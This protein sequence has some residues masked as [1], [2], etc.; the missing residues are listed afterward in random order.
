MN[1]FRVADLPENKFFEKDAIIDKKFIVCPAGVKITASLKTQLREWGFDE[2][3][4]EGEI[5]DNSPFF[6]ESES[7][8]TRTPSS[9]EIDA[10]LEEAGLNDSYSSLESEGKKQKTLAARD[11]ELETARQE[12][13]AYLDYTRNVYKKYAIT[14]TLYPEDINEKMRDFCLFVRANMRFVI[15]LQT[16][17]LRKTEGSTYIAEHSLRS[18]VFAIAIGMQLSLP[19]HRL[20]ELSVSCLLHEIGMVT[21]P[22]TFFSSSSPLSEQE[23]KAIFTHPVLSYNILRE[24][25]F[26]LNVCLGALEHHE[27]EDGS[28]YPRN[29]DK[30]RISMYAKIIS[31]A[32]S[33]EASISSRPFKEEALDAHSG[34]IEIMKNTGHRYDPKIIRALLLSISLYPIGLYVL[35]SDGKRGQ[36]TDINPEDPKHPIVQLLDEYRSDGTHKTVVTG[37]TSVFI[38]RPLTKEEQNAIAP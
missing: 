24:A 35:L 37:E 11:K 15:R 1:T 6:E 23:K 33:Y 16:I 5:I 27:R 31:V 8:S 19:Q 7:S 4:S 2:V 14:K 12:Y 32:C 13:E 17:G 10:I 9:D 28:G 30:D 20:I 3:T 22:K 29:L 36:V 21:F 38:L 26:P 34:M 18:T 25:S